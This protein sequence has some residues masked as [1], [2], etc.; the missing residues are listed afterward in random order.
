MTARDRLNWTREALRRN[1][2]PVRDHLVVLLC[3]LFPS[4]DVSSMIIRPAI[5]RAAGLSIGH[6]PWLGG[7]IR[8]VGTNM[9]I[10]DNVGIGPHCLIEL[11]AKV[12]I[13]SRV[14]IGFGVTFI[15]GHHEIGPESI[16]LGPLVGRPITVQAGAWIGAKSTILPGVT[17][18]PGAVI[19]AGSLV[20]RD[21]E[22]NTLVAGVPARFIR[23]LSP[24]A[25][26]ECA[27]DSRSRLT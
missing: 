21:V 8:L 19:S 18:G 15:T 2:N 13:E 24:C 3:G 1:A 10:G 27:D 25:G 11:S 17:I 26:G 9:T 20:A 5:L 23:R 22:A 7:G 4:D 6:K 14:N 16:R 12:T